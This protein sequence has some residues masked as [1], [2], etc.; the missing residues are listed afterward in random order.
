MSDRE[1]RQIVEA[2]IDSAVEVEVHKLKTE[3]EL[4]EAKRVVEDAMYYLDN[5]TISIRYQLDEAKANVVIKRQ[6]ADPEWWRRTN[7]A[8]RHYGR[9]RQRIQNKLGE[10]NRRLRASRNQ[11]ERVTR[12]R[13]FIQV[14]GKMLSADQVKK[15]W[16]TVDKILSEEARA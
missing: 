11:V 2:A 3:E 7:S 6:F 8:L 4:I 5:A 9:E 15:A 1:D 12:D 14:V 13:A 16:R 10:I